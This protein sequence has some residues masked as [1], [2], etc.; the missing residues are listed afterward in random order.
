M[1]SPRDIEES[2]KYAIAAGADGLYFCSFK[3]TPKDNF[4]SI[5]KAKRLLS[6]RR[7]TD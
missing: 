1:T 7:Q 5:R 2:S 6:S 3:A 4:E